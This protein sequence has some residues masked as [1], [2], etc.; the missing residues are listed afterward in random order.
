MSHV[1]TVLLFLTV[2][3][4]LM[5]AFWW[6]GHEKGKASAKAKMASEVQTQTDLSA[7]SEQSRLAMLST[8]LPARYEIRIADWGPD[9]T[10]KNDTLHRWR[11]AVIDAN[12]IVR[13][14][15][16]VDDPMSEAEVYMLGNAPTKHEAFLA[17]LGWVEQQ[18]HPVVVVDGR[19]L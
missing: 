15:L 16:G 18:K 1:F 13:V 11:W 9:F 2:L 19:H 6:Q 12:H 5:A 7:V 14:N 8:H 3:G 10:G 4:L 17:A